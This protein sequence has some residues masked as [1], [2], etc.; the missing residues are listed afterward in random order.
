MKK[1]DDSDLKYKLI[2]W[3]LPMY[4][5]TAELPHVFLLCWSE[6]RIFLSATEDV[7]LHCIQTVIS[8]RALLSSCSAAVHLA[9]HQLSQSSFWG[10][11][12]LLGKS[13]PS[14]ELNHQRTPSQ[15]FISF[16]FKP[17]ATCVSTDP[18]KK[19]SSHQSAPFPNGVFLL[20]AKLLSI[21]RHCDTMNPLSA[22]LT[23]FTFY[24]HRSFF[25]CKSVYFVWSCGMFIMLARHWKK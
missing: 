19:P 2:D 4:L 7:T 8:G 16:I 12:I 9:P 6:I 15:W 20:T 13:P 1:K 17:L 21:V 11:S 25:C 10:C 24:H 5:F 14:S 3:L 22:Y 18:T 23:I